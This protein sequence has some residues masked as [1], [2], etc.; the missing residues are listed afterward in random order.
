M[1]K[2]RYMFKMKP[3]EPIPVRSGLQSVVVNWKSGSKQFSR[4]DD[5]VDWAW[6]NRHWIGLDLMIDAFFKEEREQ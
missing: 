5:A 6:Q 1:Y 4:W 2:L 3:A